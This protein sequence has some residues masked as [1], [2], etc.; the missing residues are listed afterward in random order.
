MTD[1][2]K[3]VK[4][5]Y[6]VLDD[7]KAEDITVIDISN[8]ST[9]ADYFI[10]A[11]GSNLP[12]VQSLTNSIINELAKAGFEAKRIEGSRD[13]TWVLMDYLDVIIHIFT[14]EDRS[15][16]NLERIWQDGKFISKEDLLLCDE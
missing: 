9:I 15:F 10:I 13:S 2:K 6:K 8:I 12:H 1:F 7:K 14:E 16:Y 4:H 11:N 5:A 3:F